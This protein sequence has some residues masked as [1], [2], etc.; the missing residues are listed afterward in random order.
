MNELDASV[1]QMIILLAESQLNQ[2]HLI[3]PN[4]FKKS[5][6]SYVYLTYLFH[7]A[8]SFLRS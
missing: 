4:F 7:A 8:K 3:K 5:I 1:N 2:L 6:L